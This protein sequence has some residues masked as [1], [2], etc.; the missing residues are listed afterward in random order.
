[1]LERQGMKKQPERESGKEKGKTYC[2]S[3]EFTRERESGKEKGKT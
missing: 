2:R 1:M 3:H